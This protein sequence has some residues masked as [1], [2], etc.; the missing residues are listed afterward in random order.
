MKRERDEQRSWA[1]LR[2]AYTIERELADRL[3]TASWDQRCQLYGTLYSEWS[4]RVPTNP[5]V[6]RRNEWTC[7][8]R[9][10]AMQMQFLRRFLREWM[11]FLEIGP[12]DC[13]LSLEVAKSARRVCAI[14]VSNQIVSPAARPSNFVLAIS[15]GR[16]IPVKAAT[17]DL[18]YSNQLMEHVHPADAVEQL[19]GI[20]EALKPGGLYVCLTPNRVNGPHDISKYFDDV[21]TGFH[22][23]EYTNLEL[24][25]LFRKV[26]FR[27]VR[28]YIGARGLYTRI[29]LLPTIAAELLV[30]RLPN[31]IRRTIGLTV[32]IRLLLNIQIVAIK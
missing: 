22:L 13:A 20:Y 30:A 15:D 1:Q 4:R 6:V 31:P 26:G 10:A 8:P 14:D 3:R 17:V 32:P 5:M 12:G 7:R 19:H 25:T 11:T 18:A 2:E 16:I 23:K 24:S 28:R 9:H 27:K 21:A 29:P